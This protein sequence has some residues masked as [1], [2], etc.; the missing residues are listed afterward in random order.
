ME[1]EFGFGSW[2]HGKRGALLPRT[3]NENPVAG[4]SSSTSS[5]LAQQ[6]PTAQHSRPERLCC[7]RVLTIPLLNSSAHQPERLCCRLWCHKIIKSKTIE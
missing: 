3:K 5:T 4:G 1:L 2:E 7:T 6:L